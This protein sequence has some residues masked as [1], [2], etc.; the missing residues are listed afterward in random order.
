MHTLKHVPP[1]PGMSVAGQALAHKAPQLTPDTL[2]RARQTQA[3][4]G[5][6][7]GTSFERR[8]G[9]SAHSLSARPAAARRSAIGNNYSYTHAH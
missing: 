2:A 7:L 4:A 5:T 3:T 8:G 6:Q 1:L 9:R